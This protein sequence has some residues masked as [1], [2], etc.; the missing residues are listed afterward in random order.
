MPRWRWHATSHG[1]GCLQQGADRPRA[2]RRAAQRGARGRTRTLRR[3]VRHERSG[4]RRGCVPR[5]ARAAVAQR[6]RAATM[7]TP[8]TNHDAFAEHAPEVLFRVVNRVALIT[9]NRPAALNA[10]SYP[11]IGELAALLERCRDDDQIVAVV[12]RGAGEKGFCA[13]GDVRA[14]YRMVAQRNLVAVLRRRIPARLRDP[15]VSEA[16]GRADGRR[17]D[18][19]R[20][21]PRAGGAA[22]RDRAQQDRDA[23]DAHRP[24]ARRRRDAFPVSCRPNSSCTSG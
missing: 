22:C 9:L 16:G 17:D 18:G 20:H 13:G 4:R 2:P 6:R 23:G 19:R 24:R 8:V 5:Q 3:P 15:Y 14:L 7:S 1:S 12:L 10:L 21:G 11:M